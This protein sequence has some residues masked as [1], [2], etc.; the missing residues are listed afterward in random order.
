M[1]GIGI[2]RIENCGVFGMIVGF[3]EPTS[4]MN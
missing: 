2:A 3:G 4:A 1:R